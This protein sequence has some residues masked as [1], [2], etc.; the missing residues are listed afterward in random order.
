MNLLLALLA[1][2]LTTLT[3]MPRAL[4][5][6]YAVA[7][8]DMVV[9]RTASAAAD[10]AV[11]VDGLA[12][13]WPSPLF[14]VSYD[15]LGL[16]GLLRRDVFDEARR[17]VQQHALSPRM[18]AIADMSQPSTAKRLF[19]IDLVARKL[20][21]Q[22][23]VAHGLNSGDLMAT[24]FSN[25]NQSHQTSLGLYRVGARISSPKHGPALLLDGL[26]KGIN[27]SAR[28]REIIIHGADYVSESFIAAHGRLGRSWGCPA[29][30]RATM[31]RVIDLLADGGVLYV[32]G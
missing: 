25:R 24:Q 31:A 21:L 22:T 17:R 28:A 8:P 10:A 26:D 30:P 11:P 6:A 16:A 3:D 29:V 23:Y 4:P 27:D 18:L 9:V 14:S 15:E 32:S 2:G 20:V 7:A 13:N 1:A 5:L 12:G 19:V